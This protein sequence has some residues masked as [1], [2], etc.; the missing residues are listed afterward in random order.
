MELIAIQMMVPL[1]KQEI[2]LWDRLAIL[3]L[4]LVVLG[5]PMELPLL[6]EHIV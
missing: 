5:V 4:L 2:A 1:A 3:R 6:K